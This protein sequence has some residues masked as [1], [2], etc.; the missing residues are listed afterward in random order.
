MNEE[1]ITVRENGAPAQLAAAVRQ[2]VLIASGWLVGKG[3]IPADMAGALGTLVLVG[4]P[5]A[6]GQ[7]R[8][9]ST[10]QKIVTLVAASDKASFK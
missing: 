8:Q 5:F 6:W 1:D 10:H 7:Y 4:V 3:Y 9:W 2:I